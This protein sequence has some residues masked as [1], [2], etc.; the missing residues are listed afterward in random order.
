MTADG[1][2]PVTED[3]RGAPVLDSEGVQIGVVDAVGDESVVVDPDPDVG[4]DARASLG[5]VRDEES[6]KSL[7]RDA[8]ERVRDGG[9]LRVD[10]GDLNRG[11]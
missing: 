6:E 1:S 2:D 9:A 4:D 10:L 8:F 11:A 5:W 3:D 7:P